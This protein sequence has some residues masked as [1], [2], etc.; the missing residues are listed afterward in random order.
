METNLSL[1]CSSSLGGGGRGSDP[2]CT[3][4]RYLPFLSFDGS[5]YHLQGVPKKVYMVSQ[6]ISK[7]AKDQSG[8]DR[9]HK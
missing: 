5:P 9:R 2:I 7:D 8:V 3:M 1:F 4:S 6:K